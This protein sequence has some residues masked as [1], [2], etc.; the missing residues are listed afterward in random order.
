[1]IENGGERVRG[2]SCC[3]S[4]P[5]EETPGAARAGGRA[6][7]KLSSATC[8]FISKGL[9]LRAATA[10]PVG[11]RRRRF[12]GSEVRFLSPGIPRHPR[13][14]TAIYRHQ[15][16]ETSCNKLCKRQGTPGPAQFWESEVKSLGG[17]TDR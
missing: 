12:R 17:K 13:P 11:G 6:S 15:R 7:Q 5:G 16:R 4:L 3:A 1:M 2:R 10:R 8:S 9:Q 14:T